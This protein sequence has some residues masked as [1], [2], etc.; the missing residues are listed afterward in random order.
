MK[1]ELR[2]IF[3]GKKDH[4]VPLLPADL[5]FLQ[6]KM[7]DSTRY[8]AFVQSIYVSKELQQHLTDW[9][10]T[11]DHGMT[12][13]RSISISDHY[14]RAELTELEMVE[15]FSTSL[16]ETGTLN[17][18]EAFF[19]RWECPYCWRSAWT[20]EKDILIRPVPKKDFVISN[21][22][23]ELLV[24][25]RL[26]DLLESCTDLH[27]RPLLNR[28]NPK[29]FI[30]IVTPEAGE[31]VLGQP[32]VEV[33]QP[34]PSCSRYQL[35]L[36][37]RIIEGQASS[38]SYHYPGLTIYKDQPFHIRRPLVPITICR[39]L[40]RFGRF[41]PSE[42]PEG[43]IHKVG[44]GIPGSSDFGENYFASAELVGRLLDAGMTGIGYR[45]ANII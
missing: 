29:G 32:S 31:I 44:E 23:H 17:R 39:S 40:T 14:E 27:F 13:A 12:I 38:P 19:S 1:T 42:Q 30:Q 11:I 33:D 5:S 20:Q 43:M 25:G 41:Q 6:E 18:Q 16:D 34:C 10:R 8:G 21:T 15:L 45:P 9:S 3:R 4:V 35:V 28:S 26:K 36:R 7:Q 37:N 2:L 24:S 22:V